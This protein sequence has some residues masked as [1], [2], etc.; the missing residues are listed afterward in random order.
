VKVSIELSEEQAKILQDAADRL[1]LRPEELAQ[2]S[3][4]DLLGWLQ[5][6]FQK[7]AGYVLNKNEELYRR[8]S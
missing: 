3:L 6:D 5:A 1:G 4:A 8:L 2:A 7:A